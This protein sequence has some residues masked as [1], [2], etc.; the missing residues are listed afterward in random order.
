MD[1][2]I[3]NEIDTINQEIS[4]YQEMSFDNEMEDYLF[5]KSIKQKLQQVIID[6]YTDKEVVQKA[7]LVLATTTGCAEDQEIA[8]AILDLLNDKNYIDQK[9]LDFFCQNVATGRWL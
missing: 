4:Q 5:N 9:D 6:H 7:L 8:E 3:T 1:N 2:L